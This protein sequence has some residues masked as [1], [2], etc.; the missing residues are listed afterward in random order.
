MQ[1]SNVDSGAQLK[2]STNITKNV[3]LIATT[4]DATI[5]FRK[6]LIEALSQKGHN[7]YV[8]CN[9]YV[10]Q[11]K[12]KIETLGG[13]PIDNPLNRSG[14]NPFLDIL[15]MAKLAIKL[16]SISA[17]VVFCCQVKPVIFGTFAAKIAGV[18]RI[19]SMLE[20]LGWAFTQRP[21]PPIFKLKI[22]KYVQLI[23]YRMAFPL[24]DKILFLNSDDIDMLSRECH[25]KI[26]S[27]DII[28]AIG[29]PK[30]SIKF[31]SPN[32]NERV[33]IFVGRLLFD[34]GIREFV[35]AAKMVKQQYPATR[36]IACGDIDLG[37]PASLTKL[38]VAKLKSENQIEFTGYIQ[39]VHSYL[40]NSSL[41]VLPS[42]REGFPMVIQEAMAIG[43]PAIVTDVPGCR[44][45]VID[46]VTGFI[47]KPFSADDIADKMIFFINNPNAIVEM[48]HQAYLHASAHY[49]ADLTSDKI[50]L[51]ILNSQDQ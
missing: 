12:L 32:L 23:L 27:Y 48:G 43:R 4:A 13:I 19:V 40:R 38:D 14:L 5:N 50:A 41:I 33:F 25:L 39:D 51:D 47:V 18:P 22:V 44:Q 45:S 35:S 31:C 17:D 15:A 21:D 46:G 2:T 28:G 37:N 42:Y 9:D 1:N 6:T 16:R 10:A 49:N 8:F 11:T 7:V 29:V 30:S 34:K 24:M 26:P 3:V 36:F 20:G